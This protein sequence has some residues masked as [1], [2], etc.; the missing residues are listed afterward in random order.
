MSGQLDLTYSAS[1]RGFVRCRCGSTRVD[2]WDAPAED[3]RPAE[4]R[5]RCRACGEHV[6]YRAGS[7]EVLR[8]GQ[9]VAQ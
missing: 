4:R 2:V 5:A 3:G 1:L 6:R 7:V 9:E 8:E